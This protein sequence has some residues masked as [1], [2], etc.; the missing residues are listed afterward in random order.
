MAALRFKLLRNKCKLSQAEIARALHIARETYSR[1]ESGER[2]MTYD[3]LIALA[4]LLD[5]S[6]DYL[7]GR[8]DRDTMPLSDA[9]QTAIKKLR[10]LDT[11]GTA[12]VLALLEHEYLGSGGILPPQLRV[13]SD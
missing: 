12:S 6:I 2:E 10:R 1:Y 8:Y 9:E 7:L 5:C 13:K 3:A 4:E 11:R